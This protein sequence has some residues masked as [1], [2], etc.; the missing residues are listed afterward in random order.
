MKILLLAGEESGVMYASRLRG[1]LQGHEIRGYA[2]SGF[3]TADLAVFGFWEVL[4]RAFF[5]MRVKRTMERV[6]DEWRP[7]VVCTIDYPGMNLRLAAYAKKRGIP[8]VHVV[9]PQVWAWHQGRIPKIEASIDRLCCFFP[10]EPSLFRPG[11]A[12]FVGHPLADE[13]ARRPPSIGR[14]KGLVALLPGSRIGEIRRLLPLML[15]AVRGMEG[16]RVAIPAANDDARAEIERIAAGVPAE[17]LSRG[18]RDLL[19]RAECAVVASGTATLEAALAGCPTLLVYK[20]SALLACFLRIAITGVRHAGLANII[21][22]KSGRE[23][24]MPEL[25]QGDATAE[26]MRGYVE[27]WIRDAEERRRSSAALAETVALLRSD[28]RAMDRIADIVVQE[29]EKKRRN[30]E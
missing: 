4:K 1:L 27:R 6:I 22:E 29:A 20:V 24:P 8:A 7:D 30:G 11:F 19:D 26:R 23:C 17:V 3:A 25:L 16:V 2:E 15:E 9:C 14:E 18:A 13:Y 21:A 28:G 5:F 10:F 12:E